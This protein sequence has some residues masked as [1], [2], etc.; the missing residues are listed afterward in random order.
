MSTLYECATSYL[1]PTLLEHALEIWSAIKYEIWNGESEDFI[2]ESLRILRGLFYS[3]RTQVWES[4]ETILTTLVS[5]ISNEIYEKMSDNRQF[6]R[7]CGRM[8]RAISSSSSHMFFLVTKAVL[9]KMDVLAQSVELPSEKKSLLS[10]FNNILQAR[11][12][13]EDPKLQLSPA[14]DDKPDV[15]II[16]AFLKFRQSIV[17]IYFGAMSKVE[18]GSGAETVFGTAA[19]KGLVL[20]TKIPDFLSPAEKAMV[21]EKIDGVLL[22]SSREQETHVAALRAI[23][24]MSSRDPTIFKDITLPNFI[25]LLPES[26]STD[27]EKRKLQVTEAIDLLQDL[28]LVS[29]SSVT[30]VN[31]VPASGFRQRN[32]DACMESLLQLWQNQIDQNGW[33]AYS[34]A[35]LAAIFR[36]LELFDSTVSHS[37]IGVGSAAGNLGAA[38]YSH[39]VLPLLARLVK[40]EQHTNAASTPGISHYVGLSNP[41]HIDEITI[42]LVGKIATLA[43]RSESAHLKGEDNFLLSWNQQ[44]EPSAI[45]SLFCPTAEGVTLPQK[46]LISGPEDECLVNVLSVSLL[47]GIQPKVST[48]LYSLD[49]LLISRRIRQS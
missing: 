16:D 15:S 39:I 34:N 3:L 6:L 48:L 36:G 26:L 8:L 40:L 5:D 42:H 12:D 7:P 2:L 22:N 20:L 44:H 25:K 45:W 18:D 29:C 14:G 32:F 28:I 49:H 13:L 47:A 11:L 24:D 38:R 4:D 43:L 41:Y 19:M 35:I 31:E 23:E 33:L 37:D 27:A 21:L 9:P 30:G 17:D 46:E 1:S 10:V